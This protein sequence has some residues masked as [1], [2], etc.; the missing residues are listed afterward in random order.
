MSGFLNTSK[1]LE[2]RR[3][4]AKLFRVLCA[5]MTWSAVVILGILLVHITR[6]GVR[7]VDL[8]FLTSFP[9]RFPDQEQQ[10]QQSVLRF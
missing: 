3:R 6:Q 8:Q 4:N 9:S 5:S 1:N 2:K 7:W 10:G